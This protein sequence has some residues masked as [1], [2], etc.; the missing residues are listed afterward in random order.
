VLLFSWLIYEQIAKEQRGTENVY[1]EKVG[2]LMRSITIQLP[3]QPEI[4]MEASGADWL[5]TQPVQAKV[6]TK[7]LQQL[8][9]LLSE[10][11]QAEYSSEGKTLSE[12][13]LD[14]SAIRV[15][16]NG[17]EYALGK[18][19][20]INHYRYVLLDQRILLVNEVV[21]ELLGRGIAGFIEE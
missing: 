8:T 16:F 1:S 12:F 17:V 4:M 20:P 14:N 19:N 21:Y 6:S 10:P 3:D 13:G 15:R 2:D 7:S 18:L 11:I 9:T 5:M